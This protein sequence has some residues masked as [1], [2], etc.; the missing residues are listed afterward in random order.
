M[1]AYE[2]K[3][4]ITSDGQLDY[5]EILLKNLPPNQEVRV[6]ILVNEMSSTEVEEQTDWSRLAVEQFFSDYS[7]EDEIYNQI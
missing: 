5:S 4:K 2:F 6:I 3:A 7:E 1:K